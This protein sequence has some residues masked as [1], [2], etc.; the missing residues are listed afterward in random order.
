MDLGSQYG[1]KDL[2]NITHAP[3]LGAYPRGIVEESKV[4]DKYKVLKE[5]LRV[6]EGFNVFDTDA[7]ELDTYLV[8]NVVIPPK[9]KLLDFE[10]YKGINCPRNHLRMFY[11]NMVAYAYNEKRIIHYFQDSLSR[12]SFDWYMQLERTHVRTWEDLS[13]AFL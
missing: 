8:P 4:T 7:L 1:D 5:I 13:N 3:K 2:D 10:K 6:I 12:A 9:F 11:R